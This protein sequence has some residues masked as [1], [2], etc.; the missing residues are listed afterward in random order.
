M[1]QAILKF[2]EAAVAFQSEA[3]YQKLEAAKKAND[4]DKNLQTMLGDFSAAR[5]EL[6][7]EMQKEDSDSEHTDALEERINNLYASIMGNANMQAYNEAKD[8]I[9]EFMMYVN[10]I[11]NAAVDGEDPMQVQKPQPQASCGGSCGSCGGC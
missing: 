5:M 6:N 2:K 10:A 11:M 4:D 9:E 1:E 7:R 3:C 8:E